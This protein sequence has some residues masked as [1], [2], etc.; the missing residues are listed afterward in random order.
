[1]RVKCPGCK[2]VLYETTDKYDPDVIPFGGMLR[3]LNPWRK[4]RWDTYG[5]GGNGQG[6]NYSQMEC[7]KCGALLAPKKRLLI[8]SDETPQSKELTPAERNQIEI[9]SFFGP[10]AIEVNVDPEPHKTKKKLLQTPMIFY[11][12]VFLVI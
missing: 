6:F 2:Q 11:K 1:M 8:V 7:V 9:D 10:P 3:L 4:W 5:S 12:W